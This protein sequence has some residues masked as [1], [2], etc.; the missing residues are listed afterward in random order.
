MLA[1]MSGRGNCY[2]NAVA[3]SFLATLLGYV[4][5]AAYD[6]PLLKAA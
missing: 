1:S 4:S 3:E 2:N 5:P 6:A